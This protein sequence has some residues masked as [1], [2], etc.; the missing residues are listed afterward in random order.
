[1]SEATKGTGEELKATIKAVDMPDNLQ[2]AAIEIARA[3]VEEHSLEKDIAQYIKKEFDR[4]YGA[5]WHCIVGKNFGSYVTHES[6]NF[7]YFYMGP[8]AI[9]LHQYK[10][11]LTTMLA[12]PPLRIPQFVAP[13]QVRL[14][15]GTPRASGQ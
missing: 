6:G 8:M 7:I 13:L 15:G 1:M 9:L 5:T 14:E 4:Q 11:W 3:S 12:V 2:N 10:E